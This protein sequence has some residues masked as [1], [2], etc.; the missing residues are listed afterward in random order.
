MWEDK[1]GALDT[2]VNNRLF[3]NFGYQGL[4]YDRDMDHNVEGEPR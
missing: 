2:G 4:P 3:I 1:A